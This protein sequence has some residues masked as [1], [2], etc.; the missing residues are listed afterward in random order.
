MFAEFQ[1]RLASSVDD[2]V[3]LR[4]QLTV[5]QDRLAD[6]LEENSGLRTYV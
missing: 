2:C 5:A 1:G 4:H 6:S 3:T